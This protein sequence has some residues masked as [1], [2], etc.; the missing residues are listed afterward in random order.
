MR[1][2]GTELATELGMPRF[3]PAAILEMYVFGSYLHGSRT[4][5]ID[6]LVVWD[7]EE[8][9]P[10]EAQALRPVLRTALTARLPLDIVLLTWRETEQADFIREHGAELVYQRANHS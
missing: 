1:C 8:A 7:V 2:T 9:T 6:L 5:D 4:S 10:L 3:L